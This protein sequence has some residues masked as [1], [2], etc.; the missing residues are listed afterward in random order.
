MMRGKP[1]VVGRDRVS[2]RVQ[3]SR[4]DYKSLCQIA[5]KDRTDI[6]SLVRR[7]IARYYLIPDNNCEGKQVS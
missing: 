3:I 7:A 2:I 6:S 4:E 5:E 1:T